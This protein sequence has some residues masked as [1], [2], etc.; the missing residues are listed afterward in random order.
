[1]RYQAKAVNFGIIYGQ[2]AFGLSQELGI[3]VKQA[4]TF[5]KKYFE[6]YPKVKE[7]LESSKDTARALGY[8]ETI[9]GR[10][11]PIPEL[12]N[13]NQIIRSAAERLAT[14]TPLQGTAADLIK[15]AMIK[16]HNILKESDLDAKMILQVHDELVFEVVERDKEKLR[17]IVKNAM[18]HIFTLRVPLDVDISFGK[19][20]GEC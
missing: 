8:A 1:M 7:F 17:E 16:I 9:T 3:D 18:E 11:R 6:R 2:Q 10:K 13:K 4:S 5:I 12:D 14:N 19:N 20:W 15:L